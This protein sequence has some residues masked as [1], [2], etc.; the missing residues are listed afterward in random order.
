MSKVLN[1]NSTDESVDQEFIR[2]L[3][4][5]RQACEERSTSSIFK[6]YAFWVEESLGN[7]KS[8]ILDNARKVTNLFRIL[9]DLVPYEPFWAIR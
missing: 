8:V 9:T 5:V 6:T 1:D 4:L 3:A 2:L 7:S